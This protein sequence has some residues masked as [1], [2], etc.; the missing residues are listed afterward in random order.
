MAFIVISKARLGLDAL[1]KQN[2]EAD[3]AFV[4]QQDKTIMEAYRKHTKPS[5]YRNEYWLAGGPWLCVD[6]Y[7]EGNIH[8]FAIWNE[9]GNVYRL[10]DAGAVED[11]PF[12]YITPFHSG[13]AR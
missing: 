1:L 2:P 5:I 8:Q 6:L 11:D 9:T 12:I 4:R 13:E 3:I 7:I 10:G